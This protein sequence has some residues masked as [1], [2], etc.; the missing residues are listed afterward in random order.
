[1]QTPIS[2]SHGSPPGRGTP[3]TG[4]FHR[5]PALSLP[6]ILLGLLAGV[7]LAPPARPGPF[8]A[9]AVSLAT[10]PNGMRLL[11]KEAHATELASIQ[12]WV[13]A[14]GF[15]E[16]DQ[17]S[18]I[19]HVIEHLVF[20]GSDTR[21]PGLLD[22]EIENLGGVLEATTQK[23]WTRFACTVAS[24]H[25]PQVIRAI[26][27]ILRRPAFRPQDWQ[28]EKPVIRDE[29]AQMT[30]TPEAVVSA[31]LHDLAYQKHP[32][33]RDVRGTPA[34]LERTDL[35]AVR[36]FFQ[37]H[38]QPAS[39]TVVVVGDV[40]P[41]SVGRAVRAAFPGVSPGPP[42]PP[43]PP[44]EQPCARAE[45]RE[46]PT[47]FRVGYIGLAFPAPSV[48]DE[49]DVFAMDL[50]LTLLEHDGAGRLPR[51]LRGQAGVQA[52]FETRRQAGL[53]TVIATVPGGS[54]E[55]TEALLRKELDFVAQNPISPDE[56][57]LAKRTLRGS[58]LL[59]N[60]TLAGQAGTLGYYDAIHRWEFAS[61][62]L[63]RVEALTS[64]EIQEV[65]KKYVRPE[66]CVS[67]VL[68]PRQGE[69]KK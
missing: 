12:V 69:D 7:I 26:G 48:H 50:L 59:D 20:K 10:L 54:V 23:D 2:F 32:Y 21:G 52:T 39:M 61:H 30:Q 15:L 28:S 29:I 8:T 43:L 38:Y 40:E 6:C 1:M 37:R 14:G 31:L 27:D 13:R 64:T 17:T 22:D 11:V 46:V 36:A 51:L 49:P 33:K 47:P 3:P 58:F 62:Y 66:R 16:D 9:P 44:A 56:I 53:L 63:E 24:R 19:S 41:A 25:V 5:W 45:R 55:T 68:R 18:G 65:A 57:A 35:A 34:R 42:A 4:V 67:V 60:E